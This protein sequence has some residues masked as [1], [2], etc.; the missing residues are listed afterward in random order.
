MSC[1][2]R[3]VA[4]TLFF[5][6]PI[7]GSRIDVR[8]H[9]ARARIWAGGDRGWESV[10]PTAAARFTWRGWIIAGLPNGTQMS[11]THNDGPTA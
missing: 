1:G 11:A 7:V 4:R 10:A 6:P 9:I 3:N 2:R 5:S 8:L